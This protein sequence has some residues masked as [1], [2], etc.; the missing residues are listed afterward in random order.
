LVLLFLPPGPP[1]LVRGE[2]KAG[3][4]IAKEAFPVCAVGSFFGNLAHS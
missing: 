4:E 2:P 1:H 3:G